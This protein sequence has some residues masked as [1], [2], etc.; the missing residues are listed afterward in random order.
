MT[1]FKRVDPEISRRKFVNWALGISAGIS[2]LGFLSIVGSAR[3]ANRQTPDKLGPVPGDILVHAEGEKTGQP[4]SVAELERNP[5]RAYPQ[6]KDKSGKAFLRQGDQQTNLVGISKFPETELGTATNKQAAPQGIVAYSLVC[7]HLGCQVNWRNA[8]QTLLCPCHSGDYDMRNGA[9]VLG[10]PPPRPL[11]Q[12]PLRVD[13]D[14]LVVAATFLTPPYGVA[15]GDFEQ[16][17]QRV[18]EASKA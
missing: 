3:P 7:Q 16:Y 18:E 6:G 9:K 17:K 2:G 13:G 4:V 15:E 8:D 12:L 11:A 10:G 5:V 1:K 14:N